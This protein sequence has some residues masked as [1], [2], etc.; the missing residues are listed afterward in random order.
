MFRLFA[1]ISSGEICSRVV[2]GI[3]LLPKFLEDVSIY[4][5]YFQYSA[6]T[7]LVCRHTS[8]LQ[9][10]EQVCDDF[11]LTCAADSFLVHE[12]Q[13]SFAWRELRALLS[14]A[15]QS[16]LALEGTLDVPDQVE[17]RDDQRGPLKALQVPKT[18]SSAAVQLP[19]CIPPH[20]VCLMI[21]NLRFL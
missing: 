8:M 18:N 21:S 16:F 5:I 17:C 11:G 4:M 6:D 10:S 13:P 1:L 12:C 2:G 19:T 9:Y 3:L 20:R 15:S 7:Q 14:T